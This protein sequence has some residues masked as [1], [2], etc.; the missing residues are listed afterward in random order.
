MPV[1]IQGA[2]EACAVL[3]VIVVIGD[4]G[5]VFGVLSARAA[6]EQLPVPVPSFCGEPD[7]P[8]DAAAAIAGTL[9]GAGTT[10]AVLSTRVVT[11]GS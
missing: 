10:A 4:A 2:A 1:D 11:D 3:P 5:W 7:V 8:G 6:A 9:R